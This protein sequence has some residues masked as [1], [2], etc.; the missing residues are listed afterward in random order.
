MAIPKQFVQP[1]STGASLIYAGFNNG[2]QAFGP[3]FFGTCEGYPKHERRTAYMPILNDFT[4]RQKPMDMS[5]QGMDAT[6]ALDMTVWDEGVAQMMEQAANLGP[7]AS[8]A[9]PG[10]YRFSDV[11]SLMGLEG[12][13]CQLWIAFGNRLGA[14]AKAAYSAL[15]NGYHYLQCIPVGPT[16]DEEGAQGMIRSFQFYAWPKCNF[17][18]LINTLF[19]FDMSAI[20]NVPINGPAA[21]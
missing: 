17:Q 1:W 10:S 5:F 8:L 4:G 13:C 2:G 18:T 3:F 19:D 21:A 16:T 11:G 7:A 9:T 6:I 20:Q 15:P 12:F 14:S